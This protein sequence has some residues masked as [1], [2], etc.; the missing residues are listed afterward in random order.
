M[1]EIDKDSQEF[2]DAVAEY[3]AEATDGLKAKNTELLG[4]IKKLQQGQQIDP[5]DLQAVENE[6]DEL[7]GKLTEANK[8]LTK[9]QKA[10]EDATK[11]ADGIDAAYSE[12]IKDGALTEALTKAGVTNPVHLKAAKALLASALGVADEDGK[13]VVKA[14]DKALADFTTEWASSDEGKHFVT[15]PDT[16]G[17]GSHNGRPPT[18]PTQGGKLP[19]VADRAGRA[20]AFSERLAKAHEE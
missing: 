7:K 20:K 2:K 4:K 14:G 5:A 3:L 19:D 12:S 15:A 8:L 1:S 17:G 18:N 13:R 9:A 16:S 10:A 11:R 6:R